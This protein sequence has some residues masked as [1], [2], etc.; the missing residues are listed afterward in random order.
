MFAAFAPGTLDHFP[1]NRIGLHGR[2]FEVFVNDHDIVAV[3][4]E[5]QEDIFLEKPRWTL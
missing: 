1:Q 5:L 3:G 2:A 4:L